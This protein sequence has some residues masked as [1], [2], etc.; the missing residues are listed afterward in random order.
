MATGANYLDLQL[1]GELL[2]IIIQ[3]HLQFQPAVLAGA[4]A[5]IA[6]VAATVGPGA[7]FVGVHVRRTDFHQ[8]SKEAWLQIL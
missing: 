4:A 3:R 8:F 1:A 6:S 5:V 2:P 7:L